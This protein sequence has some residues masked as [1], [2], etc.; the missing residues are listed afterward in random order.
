[1]LSRQNRLNSKMHVYVMAVMVLV[2]VVVVVVGGW[3]AR[4]ATAL[5]SNLGS[6]SGTVPL[7]V[8]AFCAQGHSENAQ[9][10]G[11][12]RVSWVRQITKNNTIA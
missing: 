7:M 1:M 2:V 6:N 5:T 9:S 11:N 10:S 12:G 3:G 8:M 4:L